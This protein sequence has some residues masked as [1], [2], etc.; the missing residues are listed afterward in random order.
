MH[1]AVPASQ[2]SAQTSC[3]PEDQLEQLVRS[4]HAL[5]V[6][7]FGEAEALSTLHAAVDRVAHERGAPDDAA[8]PCHNATVFSP[9]TAGWEAK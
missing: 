7:L 8:T 5:A 6:S 3:A 1:S 4:A 9:T 2:R